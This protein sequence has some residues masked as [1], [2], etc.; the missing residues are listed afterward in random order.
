MEEK[1]ERKI[2]RIEDQIHPKFANADEAYD[3]LQAQ[4]AGEEAPNLE[5]ERV[6][7]AERE[8]FKDHA[9]AAHALQRR[10]DERVE[11]QRRAEQDA[12][13]ARKQ[14]D[15]GIMHTANQARIA[16]EAV[17]ATLPHLEAQERDWQQR[18]AALQSVTDPG[19]RKSQ[20]LTLQAEANEL[21]KR[22]Q[23]ITDASQTA[24]HNRL[25][26]L[27]PALAEDGKLQE[28][29]TW[30]KEKGY[31]D[32]DIANASVQDVI[33]GY[34]EW[35]RAVRTDRAKRHEAEKAEARKI[36]EGDL[37][38]VVA[39]GSTGKPRSSQEARDKLR[40]SGDIWDALNV[41]TLD[42]IERRKA[43]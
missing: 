15:A 9:D 39:T 34:D 32:E 42:K 43:L 22:R 30:A 40:R 3:A 7:Q 37:R 14:R 26:S 19:Q 20:E 29:I 4:K 12:E 33:H 16:A 13:A 25:V 1:Q 6:D 5:G 2:V 31:S 24:E 23:E 17:Q 10:R 27:R 41:V 35:Q 18:A 28:L 8:T 38:G 36:T 11:N 21:R